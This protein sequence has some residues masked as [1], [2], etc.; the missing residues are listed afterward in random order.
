[1]NFL[2]HVVFSIKIICDAFQSKAAFANH[3][4]FVIYFCKGLV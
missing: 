1:M 4:R 2:M 3:F